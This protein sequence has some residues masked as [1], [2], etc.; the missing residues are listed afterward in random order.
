M[1]LCYVVGIEDLLV[2]VGL[3]YLF[4]MLLLKLVCELCVDCGL[5]LLIIVVYWD[6]VFI[7][8]LVVLVIVDVG[9]VF[10][11]FC[12]VIL[13]IVDLIIG[14]DLVVVVWILLVFLVV[15]VVSEFVVYFV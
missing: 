5:V 15:W 8:M 10:D 14:I 12:G 1:V 7:D 4:G 2:S 9:V 11:D 6:F 13:W 3:M